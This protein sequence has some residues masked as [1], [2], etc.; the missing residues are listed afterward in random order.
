MYMRIIFKFN[1]LKLSPLCILCWI[2]QGLDY[3]SRINLIQWNLCLVHLEPTALLEYHITNKNP[4]TFLSLKWFNLLK[5]RVERYY[6][7]GSVYVFITADTSSIE[8][9]DLYIMVH[10]KPFGFKEVGRDNK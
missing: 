6:L 2:L 10:G 5:S 8:S 9:S 4:V 3:L 1:W 7:Q